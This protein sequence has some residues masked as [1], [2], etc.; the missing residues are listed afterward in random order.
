MLVELVVNILASAIL[1]AG[2][3]FGGMYRERRS[4]QGKNL[5]E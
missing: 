1:M 2:G 3:Y 5:E 4:R